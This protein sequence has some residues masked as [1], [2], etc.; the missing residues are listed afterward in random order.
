[1]FKML[2]VLAAS[3]MSFGSSSEI[4]TLTGEVLLNGEVHAVEYQKDPFLQRSSAQLGGY[5]FK[6]VSA[7]PNS[8]DGTYQETVNDKTTKDLAIM[9][10]TDPSTLKD[11]K[12]ASVSE[13]EMFFKNASEVNCKGRK[14]NALIVL[15]DNIEETAIGNCAHL[16]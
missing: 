16:K 9:I 8:F 10:N 3:I 14:L 15:M 4:K 7:G 5:N 13:L 11:M 6:F 1:M 2:S 12:K